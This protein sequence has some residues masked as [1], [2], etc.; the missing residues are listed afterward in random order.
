[1]R[2]SRRGSTGGGLFRTITNRPLKLVSAAFGIGA[3]ASAVLMPDSNGNSVITDIVT[4]QQTQGQSLQNLPYHITN[5]LAQG[6]WIAPTIG[7]V[8]TGYISKRF[9]V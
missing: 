5:S 2:R 8:V 9:K 4:A 3:V 1:M 7:A 6:Q